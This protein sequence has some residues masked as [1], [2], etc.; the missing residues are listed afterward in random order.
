MVGTLG[1][2]WLRMA[3][4]G[5]LAS[6]APLV[7]IGL[8]I[9]LPILILFAVLS[10]PPSSTTSGNESQAVTTTYLADEQQAVAQDCPVTDK[11]CAAVTVPFVQAIMM[12]ES[13]G[14]PH[15]TSP[16]GAIGLMQVMP[17]HFAA[18]VDPY[19]PLIN[20]TEGV[21]ILDAN[22]GMFGGHLSLV[23]AA[24]NA[25]PGAV[26]AWERATHS[27]QWSVLAAYVQSQSNL[28]GYLQTVHYVATVMGYYTHHPV[29]GSGSSTASAAPSTK[30]SSSGSTATTPSS[31]ATSRSTRSA[32][33]GS[34]ASR[35]SSASPHSSGASHALG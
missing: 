20:I 18:G 24:Y 1:R 22:S 17:Y 3:L 32:S 9:G 2:R 27:T 19:N 29:A 33:S 31:P 5:S 21:K 11:A 6:L 14:H 28:Q 35:P 26:Q 23:A 16:V 34:G 10:P 25:G 12:A 4:W 13:G 30:R 15:V 8:A 7:G